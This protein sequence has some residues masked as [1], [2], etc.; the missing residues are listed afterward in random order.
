MFKKLRAINKKLIAVVLTGLMLVSGAVYAL[1]R[2]DDGGSG[3]AV[4]GKGKPISS[5]KFIGYT[6]WY[7][8]FD[9]EGNPRQGWEDTSKAKWKGWIEDYTGCKMKPEYER[10]YNQAANQALADARAR[11]G[12]SRARIVGVVGIAFKPSYEKGILSQA[13]TRHI[14]KYAA[15]RAGYADAQ[16]ELYEHA[17]WSEKK[18]GKSWRQWLYEYGA[19]KLGA[20][21]SSKELTIMVYAVAEGEPAPQ[22]GKATVKKVSADP[23][24][25]N[26]NSCYSLEG[27]Q[28][29]LAD[30]DSKTLATFTLDKNGNSNTV[31]IAP[32]TYWIQETK[33]P[34][35][36]ALDK[37]WHKFEVKPNQTTVV[38]VEDDPLDDPQTLF[39]KKY[40]AQAQKEMPTGA[41]SLEGAEFTVK[42]YDNTD[43]NN[44]GTPKR[45][46]VF[47]TNK[48]GVVNLQN[49]SLKIAG[50]NLFTDS[51]NNL[52]MPLGTYTI[53]E[54]KAPKGYLINP[55]LHKAVVVDDG[56]G[57]ASWKKL[58]NWDSK[59]YQQ[60][61][62]NSTN[63]PILEQ[64]IRGSVEVHK[65]DREL[66][67][68][69]SQGDGSLENI[70][71]NIINKNKNSVVIDGKTARPEEVCATITTLKT[72]DGY[73]AKTAPKTL[74]YG[75]YELVEATSNESYLN[76]GFKQSFTIEHDN[77]HI[78]FDG[79]TSSK[80]TVVRGGVKLGKVDRELMKHLPLGAATLEGTEFSVVNSSK[81]SVWVNDTL[82]EPGQVVAKLYADKTGVVTTPPNLLPYGTYTITETK[83]PK[84]YLLNTTYSKVVQ[85][86]ENG[87][88]Y[89]LSG[90]DTSVADQVVRGDFR[91][92]KKDDNNSRPMAHIVF[93]LTSK[94]TGESHIVVSDANGEVNTTNAY[95]PH[96]NATNANDKAVSAE[97]KVD[98]S[99]LVD[100]A[101]VWFS[102][103]TDTQTT[104]NNRLGAL[105]YDTYVVE[106]LATSANTHKKLVKFEV[107]ITR[108]AFT[109]DMDSV[110][111]K[112]DAVIETEL[113]SEQ[114][115]HT[116][117]VAPTQTLVDTLSAE[118]LTRGETYTLVG[119]LVDKST[120]EVLVDADGKEI[121]ASETFTAKKTTHE[122]KLTFKLDTS[123]LQGK[124]IVAFE[125][126]YDAAGKLITQETDLE[127]T[128]QT[129]S[130]PGK[131]ET[132]ALATESATHFVRADKNQTVSDKVSYKNL[133]AGE[134]Y[135]LEATLM[136]KSTGK[137]FV[138]ADGKTVTA[139]KTFKASSSTGSID[140]EFSF[141][142][143]GMKDKTLVVFETLKQ[144]SSELTCEAN[145][146]N[147][148]QTIYTP[149]VTTDAKDK[150]SGTKQAYADQKM[151]IVDV[152]TYKN[153]IVGKTY[154]VTGTLMDKSTGK[155]AVDDAGKPITATKTFVAEKSNGT[156]ELEFVFDGKT[157]A[158]KT[159]V[160][161]ER[162]EQDGKL[163]AVHEDIEDDAQT[164]HVAKL[165]TKAEASESSTHFVRADKDQKL[166][167][168]VTYKN[169]IVGKTYTVTGTL[170]DKTTGKALVDAAGKPITA[171]KT[172]K[173]EKS[174]GEITLE[175]VV[176]ATKLGGKTLVFF[177][178]LT[179]EGKLVATHED[180][181]DKD[182]SIFVPAVTTDA[183]D[184][185]T[186]TKQAYADQ[187][188]TIVDV[189]T[190]KNLIVGKTY[191]VTG[192]LM[193]KTTGKAAVDDQGKPITATKTFVAEK[194][195]GTV[196]LEFVFDG[197]TLA[198]KTV[199][200]FERLTQNGKLV[201]A[202]EDIEDEAQTVKIVE[203][204][205][206]PKTGDL[207][208]FAIPAGF[209][210][211]A[212]AAL[213]G[214][215]ILRKRNP[216]I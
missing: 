98:E 63:R 193:D 37:E 212:A 171:T 133:V 110:V 102:G 96:N 84:G 209:T 48:N 22:K 83:A 203:K 143:T 152:V 54:T 64:V 119:K 111:N 214:A 204:P 32:G 52:V 195:D 75:S 178:K 158:G 121:S 21:D 187:K 80:D 104:V 87:K 180:L 172:F 7:D 208:D 139:T 20:W 62:P 81:S 57:K 207:S 3:G 79:N 140:V 188:M 173:A 6:I 196:E 91:F 53:Q 194:S 155:A 27:A 101:G 105:P 136:D 144:E 66:E 176:D 77:Q 12:K 36:Y 200:A 167:D 109:V 142:A 106:E 184:K 46:W 74:P 86:R 18:Q 76:D 43:G 90:E 44:S 183:K 124:S 71:Y 149:G 175:F 10:L 59:L 128:K 215:W 9:S 93:R 123:K 210:A 132:L 179:C 24:I 137:A 186:G 165:E 213:L 145:L 95:E 19:K 185:T 182:Q 107:S 148:E 108:P 8:R 39:L 206:L 202:H 169:L 55:E 69:N 161:F 65:L 47:K 201:A 205:S 163:V 67:K 41:G 177:E 29:K 94:T 135:T 60:L 34:K 162:L 116:A 13:R 14:L 15:G 82:Y 189:V 197:K 115:T 114:L 113:L 11:S 174:D 1:A 89:D 120:G 49:K 61:D 192:T 85:V 190:Y 30:K 154:T 151:T 50:D 58:D 126:L 70:T 88:I 26:N 2:P 153:L 78:V 99:K 166:T 168:T 72:S 117:A 131:L 156:V 191:T 181:D 211:I 122:V 159:V 130:V 51:E 160:A 112:D 38:K 33:A 40:D 4:A 31:E 147:L 138:D 157:L 199:V 23:S 141:N 25:T 100:H 134:T 118:Q 127:N 17:G 42:Y 73:V 68:S 56:N 97:G 125:Y 103:R 164:V 45:T 146:E 170:M 198:G 28:Y 92:T 150:T 216:R 5:D 16:N 129:V 35:G